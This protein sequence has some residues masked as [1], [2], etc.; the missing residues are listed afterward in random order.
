MS[1]DVKRVPEALPRKPNG[2]HPVVR[3]PRTFPS[4][5]PSLFLLPGHCPRGWRPPSLYRRHACPPCLRVLLWVVCGFPFLPPLPQSPPL[6]SS[7]RYLEP[8]PPPQHDHHRGREGCP[9]S[10]V[11]VVVGRG[12]GPCKTVVLLRHTRRSATLLVGQR[13]AHKRR[14]SA[15]E[16]PGPR[17][18]TRWLGTKPPP[19]TKR[20]T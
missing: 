10:T 16:G 2:T 14:T 8:T 1:G 15:E 3:L 20:K 12:P 5:S 17:A 19:E 4:C 18:Q 11:A 13:P 6:R 9:A 7:F